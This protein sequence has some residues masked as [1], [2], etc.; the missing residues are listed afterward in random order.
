MNSMVNQKAQA[1][2]A[3][4][5]VL[6]ALAQGGRRR[7]ALARPLRVVRA[8]CTLSRAVLPSS[9]GSTP[10][11]GQSVGTQVVTL[12]L[13]YLH[14]R[15]GSLLIYTPPRAG[16]CLKPISQS[17]PCI[18]APSL[19]LAFHCRHRCCCC[20]CRRQQRAATNRSIESSIITV[21]RLQLRDGI[22]LTARAR[23]ASWPQRDRSRRADRA[24]PTRAPREASRRTAPTQALSTQ[25]AINS[26]SRR[27]E[28]APIAGCS[29]WSRSW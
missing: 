13:I 4:A 1:Q 27:R 23:P 28:R 22:S 15:A 11:S 6:I 10:E 12:P 7:I 21:L 24:T 3:A 25:H 14:A 16:T 18:N 9:Q 26:K 20:C 17:S 8:L 5:A 19:R 29:V 2:S